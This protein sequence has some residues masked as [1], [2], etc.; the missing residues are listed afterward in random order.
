MNDDDLLGYTENSLELLQLVYRDPELP[1][2]VRMR[3]AM[4]AL[5]FEHP[6]LAVVAQVDG[7]G[8]AAKLEAAITASGKAVVISARPALP[9]PD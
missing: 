9:K 1:L 6:K 8:W 2:P 3:A 5:P 7:V 4:A